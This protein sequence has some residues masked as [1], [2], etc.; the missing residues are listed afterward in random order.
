MESKAVFFSGSGENQTNSERH[1]YL[2]KT[3]AGNTEIT[4]KTQ[5]KVHHCYGNCTWN[6]SYSFLGK[7]CKVLPV[8]FQ[9][10]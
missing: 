8:N 7:I 5:L 1:M 3:V 10:S 4:S 6:L 9:D 2:L